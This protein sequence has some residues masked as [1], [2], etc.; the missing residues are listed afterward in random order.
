M[1]SLHSFD[2]DIAIELCGTRALMVEM[3][4]A[5]TRLYNCLYL[6]QS[7]NVG[8]QCSKHMCT[9]MDGRRMSSVQM[10]GGKNI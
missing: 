10:E 6:R 4:M 8:R 3:A 9:G 7:V 5:M 2:T 1:H